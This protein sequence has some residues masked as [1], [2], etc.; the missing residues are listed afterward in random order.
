MKKPFFMD[1][2]NSAK[3]HTQAEFGRL[4]IGHAKYGKKVSLA[5][6]FVLSDECANSVQELTLRE[7]KR[8]KK[9]VFLQYRQLMKS[10]YDLV[11]V[12]LPITDNVRDMRATPVGELIIPVSHI[13][14]LIERIKNDTYSLTPSWRFLDGRFDYGLYSTI[15]QLDDVV[16]SPYTMLPMNLEVARQAVAAGD[17]D[18][19]MR[20]EMLERVTWTP[21]LYFLTSLNSDIPTATKLFHEVVISVANKGTN[22]F[23]ESVSE[24]DTLFGAWLLM[25]NAKSGVTKNDTHYS[26][27]KETRALD[28]KTKLPRKKVLSSYR[29]THITMSDY[30][31]PDGSLKPSFIEKARHMVRGHFKRRATGVFWWNPFMRGSS[32]KSSKRIA[33]VCDM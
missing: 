8:C 24:N 26:V 32:D 16:T 7:I 11:W 23:A 5:Q 29:Y 30:E 3:G 33:Y 27:T 20:I 31:N 1:W 22:S 28:P 12:E 2:L 13:G 19:N 18:E 21:N 17:H 4:G 6:R 9:N 10:P 14:M 25:L 15:V